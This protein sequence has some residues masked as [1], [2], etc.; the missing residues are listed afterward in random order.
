MFAASYGLLIP[1]V[2]S[3]VA[4]EPFLIAAVL[5]GQLLPAV[6]VTGAVGGRPAVRKL[7]GRVFRWRVHLGWYLLALL[8]VPA[9]TLLGCALISGPGVLR[10]L[11]SDPSVVLTYLASLTIL[12]VV[13]L[14]EE[15]AWMGV[16]QA[17]LGALHGP[18]LAAV[19][20]GPLFALLHL[21]LQLGVPAAEVALSMGVLMVVAIPLRLVLGW[22][23]H[24][25]GRSILLVAIWHAGFNATSNSPLVAGTGASGVLLSV[26]PWIV[27]TL[28]AVGILLNGSIPD[29][30][31]PA[32]EKARA[33]SDV[34]RR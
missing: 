23:Y 32:P 11:V 18:V 12:P 22:L 28:W 30:P 31:A 5:L 3:G 14:W 24:R 29:E 8:A 26:T 33:A 4:P 7:F 21:P 15:T 9:G 27:V 13:N 34:E 2:L 1:A 16:V 19:L 20:T 6:L 17:R 25:T 10:T